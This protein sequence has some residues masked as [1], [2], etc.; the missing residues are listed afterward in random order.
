MVIKRFSNMLGSRHGSNPFSRSRATDAA[1]PD[2]VV[3]YSEDSPEGSAVK[4]VKLFCESDG[5]NEQGEEVLHLPTIVEAAESSPAAAQVA[6]QQIRK[7]LGKDYYNRPHVQYNAVML[8]RILSENPGATFTRNIDQK[9]TGAVKELLRNNKDPSVQQIMR[10]TLQALYMEKAYD[11]N[12]ATLFAMWSKESGMNISQYTRASGAGQHVGQGRS[13]QQQPVPQNGSYGRSRE[14]TLPPPVE[15]AARIEEAKTS[16]KLLQQLVQSTPPSELQTNELIKEFAERCQ[17]AQRSMH[18]FMNCTN[19]VPDDETMQTLIETSEQLSLA[20]SKHQRAV[21]QA[22]RAGH[23]ASPA[24][25]ENG[26][27]PP[28]GPPPSQNVPNTGYSSANAAPSSTFT[29]TATHD[30][31]AYSPPPAPPA[32]MRDN[33]QRRSTGEYPPSS[34]G[35]QPPSLK[36]AGP[37][38]LPQVATEEDPFSDTNVYNA[39]RDPPPGKPSSIEPVSASSYGEEGEYDPYRTTHPA[40]A[41]VA[42]RAARPAAPSEPAES[43]RDKSPG[44]QGSYNPGYTSTPSYVRRQESGGDHLTMHGAGI[45]DALPEERI[46][47]SA[48]RYGRVSPDDTRDDASRLDSLRG[49]VSPLESR[50]SGP[51]GSATGH[52]S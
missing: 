21:L 6:A 31:Q 1:E 52:R 22:R 46:T 23:S 42:A 34:M 18:G 25:P 17:N 9:F 12:L 30:L 24:Q 51:L 40:A 45:E 29:P 44:S 33:L 36:P 26:Y 49:D 10:E 5:A 39:P 37:P 4:A 15:L 14:T 13:M 27:V 50:H 38:R 28:A 11:T 43:W 8:I 20:A 16:A 48:G 41:I 3:N 7:F 2:P 32:A 35:A 47:Q 19:P